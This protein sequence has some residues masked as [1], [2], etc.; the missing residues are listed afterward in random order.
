MNEVRELRVK[1]RA[2]QKELS[3]NGPPDEN[4]KNEDEE[5]DGA[6]KDEPQGREPSD[7]MQEDDTI[8]AVEY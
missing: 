2:V 5:M 3:E 1:A 6:E 8:D 7:T 4:G